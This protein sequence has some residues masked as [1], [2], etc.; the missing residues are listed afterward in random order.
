[1][2]ATMGLHASA[3][4]WVFNVVRELLIAAVGEDAVGGLYAD[5]RDQVP[6]AAA[7]V[8]RHLVIKPHPGSAELDAWLAQH[9]AR[10]L[11]SV[12]DPRDAAVSMAQR[13]AAPLA[14]AVRWLVD[15]CNRLLRLP[16]CGSSLLRYE[17]RFFED[18][19]S[20]E[21]L[22]YAPGLRPKPAI[23]AA[24][25]AAIARMRCA[26]SPRHSQCAQ[27]AR[28]DGGSVPDGSGDA[29]PR[30]PYRRQSHR[31]VAGLADAIPNRD[32][33][34][35]QTIPWSIWICPMNATIALN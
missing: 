24:I 5:R 20:I 7:R 2:I 1:L 28:D 10:V 32:G 31:Q 3:S 26:P 23:V 14:H 35:I 4:T 16:P 17:D 33:A 19:A 11:I 6:D 12:H 13:F 25:F 8:G 18:P 15:D 27:R 22:A 30:S 9:G 34:R 29:D 21:G